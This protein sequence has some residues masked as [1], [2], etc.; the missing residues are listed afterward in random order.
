MKNNNNTEK[1]RDILFPIL[2]TIVVIPLIVRLAV[3]NCGYSDYIWYSD[4]D[5]VSDLYCYFKSYIF[6]ITAI[7]SVMVLGFRMALYRE[8][9]KNVKLFIPM[10]VYG[11]FVI[12]ST[13]L[14][15]NTAASLEGNF[16]SFE[17]CLVLIGYVIMAFYTYQVLEEDADYR[18]IWLGIAVLSVIFAIIGILQVFKC[19]L[20][21]FEFVQRLIMSEEYFQQYAGEIESSFSGNNVYLT[22]YNPNYAGIVLSMLFAVVFVMTITE[23]DKK[24]KIA[25]A[26]LTGILAVLT[27]FTY[28]RT[29]LITIVLVAVVGIFALRKMLKSKTIRRIAGTILLGIAVLVAV[30]SAMGFK[31]LS[32]IFEG[33]TREPL[34][35]MTTDKEGIHIQYDGV[36]Y[37]LWFDEDKAYCLNGD[38]N[39]VTEIEAN[40]DTPLDIGEGNFCYYAKDSQILEM[41][42]LDTTLEFVV[43]EGVYYYQ[44][45]YGN[46][47]S[48]V[49]VDKVSLGGLEYIASARGY[50]WS[51]TLPL[52]KD[53]ILVGSGPDTYPEVF[54]QNDYA[55]KIV[56]SDMPDR[57]IEK[58]HNDYLTKWVHTGLISVIAMVIFYGIV[59]YKGG[60]YYLFSKENQVFDWKY[61]LGLGCYLACISYMIAGLFNDST[62]QTAP[63]FWIFMG[64]TLASCDKNE[65]KRF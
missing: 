25:L 57:I 22:L 54:P 61:R 32:K 38:T 36:I 2:F 60:K 30:D 6:D 33:N 37:Q 20:L 7:I 55:G 28:S 56:Y 10:F 13:F 14:S 24:K 17:S 34:E 62:I 19:D 65:N 46:L 50:I 63:L 64:L 9:N 16:E 11:L 18:I 1:M 3:Y 52:L 26:V 31:Y 12:I 41:F 47:D 40:T 45:P 43:E 51:R 48:M 59:I 23:N 35:S 29:S 4:D 5:L 42:F 53:Y 21:D 15:I 49:D 58:G 39:E 44:T 27:W 8:K